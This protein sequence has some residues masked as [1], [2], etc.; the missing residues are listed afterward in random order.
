MSVN[1][2]GITETGIV[3]Y[4]LGLDFEFED[5]PDESYLRCYYRSNMNRLLGS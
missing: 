1:K 5:N 4:F 2:L 3:K